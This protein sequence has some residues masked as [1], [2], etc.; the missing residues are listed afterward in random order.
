MKKMSPYSW[1]KNPVILVVFLILQVHNYHV[2]AQSNSLENEYIKVSFNEQGLRS[3]TDKRLGKTFLFNSDQFLFSLN[4]KLFDSLSLKSGGIAAT[5]GKLVY[6]FTIPGFT[7]KV[8][9]ELGQQRFFLSKHLEIYPNSDSAFRVDGICLWK[10]NPAE[11]LSSY[12]VPHTRRP[13]LK[14]GD[15]GA[16]LRFAD[17]TGLL[18]T[19]QNP[20]LLFKK[21]QDELSLDYQPAMNWKKEYGTFV[22]D[23]AIIG[24][25][26]LTGSRIPVQM[27][28]EWKQATSTGA[29]TDEEQ[30]QSEIEAFTKI[31]A[32]Y[33]LPQTEKSVK[34]NVGWCENDYQIDIAHEKGRTEYKRII[35]Q[36]AALGIDHIL[37]APSNSALGKRE[38]STDDWGWENLL[39]LGL[40]IQIRKGEWNVDKDPVPASV[41]EMLDYAKSKHVKL[42]AYIYPVL[43]FAGNPDWIVEGTPYQQKKRNASLGVRSFQDYMITTIGKFYE[44]TGI[45]G[46]SYDYT[47]LWYEG[48]SRYEQWKGW[49]R[50]KETL[51]KK[52]PAMVIDGR[53]LDQLYGPWSW[54]SNS[55]PHPTNE[56][57]QPESFMPFP[58]LHFDRVSANRQRYTAYRYR[59]NDYCP[60]A[61]MP[62]FMFHQTPRMDDQDGRPVLAL[63]SFHRRDWDYLGWKYSLFSSIGTGG[64]NN[65]VNMIPARDPEEFKKFSEQDKKFIRN[66]LNWTDQNRAFLLETKFILGQPALGKTDGTSGIKDNKGYIFL[67]N[68]NYQRLPVRF[69]LDQS[70]GLT[71]P[72]KYT[73]SI[74]YPQE[75]KRL[76]PEGNALYWQHG[77]VFTM[78]M[79]GVSAVVLSI[80]EAP[81]RT[82]EPIL[83]NLQGKARLNG[84][85]LFLDQVTGETGSAANWKIE[86]PESRIPGKVMIN[87]KPSRFTRNGSTVSGNLNFNGKSLSSIHQLGNVDPGFTGGKYSGSFTIPSWVFEQL[88]QRKKAWP[89]PWSQADY[90]TTWL[91]PERLLLFIQIAEPEDTM[92]V[93]MSL[94]GQPARLTKAYSSV[95][96]NKRS[97]VGWYCD[98]TALKA[99]RLYAVDV[100]LPVL[101]PGQF[102]GIF[103]ENV[104]KNFTSGFAER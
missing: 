90:K 99:E 19:V 61:I 39:W 48:T 53:Q 50:V 43:P 82:T 1:L 92:E 104:E 38:E 77:D 101:R 83:F 49:C 95:R 12:Y 35:D 5:P 14:T 25:Y 88:E 69:S 15:Y 59:I 37:F 57:E 74:L 71:K 55:F 24:A 26:K 31:V 21:D 7:A 3:L 13:D 102:Q 68:P 96:P 42:I 11:K 78:N 34:M 98:I 9:Y 10:I 97:F 76:S 103:F 6:S 64:L 27:V 44:R 45:S 36:N 87:G 54:L 67:F 18:M 100:S 62:G 65:V 30:D 63:D 20:F 94:N 56:D 73:I 17:S 29:G 23:I 93:K 8:V 22:S 91:A 84:T 33:V 2:Y 86:M 66:W 60:P 16:F 70:I 79:D 75:G 41:Q 47:F 32:S 80:S 46:F 58:D 40:G 4:G 51:R 85:T 81:E 28:P 52:Y 89:I 72:G